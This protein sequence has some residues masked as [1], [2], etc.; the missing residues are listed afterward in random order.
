VEPFSPLLFLPKA[1]D[2]P[3]PFPFLFIPP[4][5]SHRLLYL[6]KVVVILFF[7]FPQQKSP[8]SLILSRGRF[9]FFDMLENNP[10]LSLKKAISFI[11]L[12]YPQ[13]RKRV[14]SL[15]GCRQIR[16][17]RGDGKP[18]SP[19]FLVRCSPKTFFFFGGRA[20]DGRRFSSFLK[21]RT[22]FFS[23][24]GVLSLDVC[25][26]SPFI[27]VI[28]ASSFFTAVQAGGEHRA[29]AFPFLFFSVAGLTAASFLVL[30][31]PLPPPLLMKSNLRN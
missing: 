9:F 13:L 10:P 6:P 20:G 25:G 5:P 29:V 3:G 4:R 26:C 2:K 12:L 23:L 30:F 1:G 16:Y 7:F 24:A 21:S 17:N 11:L 19:G 18:F 27:L 22:F 8:L 14:L 28:T 31:F 15:L